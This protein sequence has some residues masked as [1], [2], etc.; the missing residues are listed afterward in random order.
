MLRWEQALAR[1]LHLL[2]LDDI[3]RKILVFA[4]IATLI[5]SLTMGWLSYVQNSRVMT[6]KVSEELRVA[7]SQASRELDIWIKQRI[8]ELRV[9]SSS[10]EVSENLQKSRGGRV[11]P[12]ALQRLNAY[13]KSVSE[14]F[15]DY[16]E[17]LVIN[18]DGQIVTSSAENPSEARLP[19]NWL[20]RARAGDSI[21]GEAYPDDASGQTVVRIA[22]PIK[23]ADDQLLGLL[24]TTL[25]F[26]AVE[27]LMRKLT[28][29]E[30]VRMYLIDTDGRVITTSNGALPDR[31]QARLPETV[32]QSLIGEDPADET[33]SAMEYRNL[34]GQNVLGSVGLSS[35][36]E[37]GVLTEISV[38]D[39]YE[40]I[41]RIRNLTLLITVTVLLVIG[42]SAYLLG[43]TIVRPLYRLTRG[44]SEVANGNLGVE[45]PPVGGGE[46]GYLTEVFNY[47]VGKLRD[48]QAELAA[49]NDTLKKTNEEL[50]EISITDSL[51]GLYNRRYMME[52]LT[53]EVSRASRMQHN[54]AVLMIDIDHFK[55]Y[56]DT[57]GHLAGDELLTKISA[58]FRES[59]RDMDLAARYGGE[60][61]L[62]ILP[63]HGAEAAMRVA[64]RIRVAVATATSDP[65]NSKEP[66]TVSIGVAAF[67]D[68]GATPVTLIE[69]ADS[70][71][72]LGK[73]SGRNRVILA[74][75]KLD[76]QA[77]KGKSSRAR[78]AR[79]S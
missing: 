52:A 13:I 71:L 22:V 74:E 30:T 8:Y 54:F 46:I 61:F 12:D 9:F 50:Q 55:Q 27:E 21:M 20:L 6:E 53:N 28:P 67:P 60:E 15:H 76:G 35:Q 19:G 45:V 49:V 77:G 29:R 43:V 41:I 14:K 39:A 66:V 17:L 70:A 38:A 73:E 4:L 7:S 1:F 16:E 72:Y 48:D 64:E 23:S 2:R 31:K 63:E 26:G 42:M 10:Y 75:A 36:Q 37:W 34:D 62:I 18:P 51:T 65:D 69:S 32:T 59:I 25:N 33:S 78:R 57:Y 3:K 68:N 56:N 79:N 58:I 24:A 5:P 40:Q 47:M 44:A 11:N